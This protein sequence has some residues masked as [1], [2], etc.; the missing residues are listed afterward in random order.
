MT[1]C[2]VRLFLWTN[3]SVLPLHAVPAALAEAIFTVIGQRVFFI[4]AV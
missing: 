4:A 2:D 1:L 3:L